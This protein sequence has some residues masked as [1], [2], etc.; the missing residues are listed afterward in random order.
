MKKTKLLTF[1]AN[2]R[3][4][5]RTSFCTPEVRLYERAVIP[6]I[7]I[8]WLSVIPIGIEWLGTIVNPVQPI[9]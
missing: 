8:N 6:T 5:L 7:L 4:I 9:A 1:L 2:K 3:Q